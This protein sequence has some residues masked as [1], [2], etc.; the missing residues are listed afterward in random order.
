MAIMTIAALW[1][2]RIL[3]SGGLEKYERNRL[4]RGNWNIDKV[5][6]V[7]QKPVRQDRDG[8]AEMQNIRGIWDDEPVDPKPSNPALLC[9]N[10]ESNLVASFFAPRYTLFNEGGT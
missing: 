10:L 9:S 7:S 6:I 5:T 3:A 1:M 4:F 8:K 2:V